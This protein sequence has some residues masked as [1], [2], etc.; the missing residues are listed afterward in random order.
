MTKEEFERR[1]VEMQGT[2]YRVSATLL[3][4]HFD[5]EDAISETVLKALSRRERLRDDRAMQSWVIRIL[6]NECRAVYRRRAREMPSDALPE[7]ECPPDANPDILR[8]LSTL[9]EPLRLCL[10]LHYSEGYAVNEIARMLR[11]PAGT[12]KSRLSRARAALRAQLHDE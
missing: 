8:A 6:I 10:T 12:V 4:S 3:R 5:R 2:L 7:P 11:V 9:P 1:I